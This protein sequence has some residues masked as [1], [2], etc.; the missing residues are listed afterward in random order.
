M[1]SLLPDPRDDLTDADLIDH[2]R[3][4][5]D[6]PWL[7][8]NMVCSAD[9]AAVGPG[10]RAGTLGTAG[11][12][13]LFSVLRGLAD[14]ILAGAG[15]ARAER[16]GPAEVEPATVAHR[17][18]AGMPP[19][20]ALAVVSAR[21][22]LDPDGPLLSGGDERVLVITIEDAPAERLAAVR[23]RVE[24][25]TAGTGL[26]DLGAAVSALHD[27]GLRQVLCEGGPLLLGTAL[28]VGLVDELCVTVSPLA[29]GG[30][31]PRIVNGPPLDPPTQF[32]LAGLLEEDGALFTRWV[33]S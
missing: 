9:G 20:A 28:A 32:S 8:T 10:G 27:R 4:P 7:R 6:R 29:V 31:A 30:S 26:V 24:V 18:A 23:E 12:R 17:A 25:I 33:R 2:Y 22:D 21:L 15:T 1:R 11:D 13:R 5:A 19:T 16:Y 3:Y 14:V